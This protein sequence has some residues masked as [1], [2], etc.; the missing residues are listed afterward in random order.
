MSK[1]AV[2]E[3]QPE[4]RPA[5]APDTTPLFRQ[6][7]L[8]ERRT[9]WLG[10]VLLEPRVS[11]RIAARVAVFSALA[12]I[13]I[14]VFGN[15][16]RKERISGWLVPDKGIVRV[17]APGNGIVTDLAVKEGERVAKG[18]PLVT[19]SSEVRTETIGATGEEIV[20]KLSARRS[21]LLSQRA[22]EERLAAQQ[23]DELA[24]R[25][26]ALADEAELLSGEISLQKRRIE[27]A[28]DSLSRAEH[29]RKRGI[30]TKASLGS[31]EAEH[32]DQAAKL[33]SLERSLSQVRRDLSAARK[34]QSDLP[35]RTNIR[36]GDIDREVAAVE[37][38]IAEAEA[39][40]QV[41][42]AAPQDGIV[43]AIQTEPGGNV[44]PNVPMLSIV[45][46]GSRLQAQLFSPSR[47]IGFLGKGSDVL[48]R[49]QPFP[50][51]NFGFYKGKIAS[52]SMTAMSPA[53]LPQQ[54][55]GLSEFY[56][57]NAPV[58]RITVDLERQDVTAYGRKIPLQAGM[59]LE[60]DVLIESH[61][62]LQWLLYPIFA[63]SD[64]WA[65]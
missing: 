12:V 10:T 53:E 34:E 20:R 21:T 44:V 11:H 35:Y 48:L 41:V 3:R 60:A 55:A 26:V 59:Q 30:I 6:E 18:R 25:V 22:D 7:A 46:E 9:Q 13:A 63:K 42:V 33:Q 23:S 32:I 17:L 16:T 36:L 37:Q 47:A 65:Q 40:R 56:G 4:N 51:Q 45:P 61:S 5:T 50:Y 27:L 62:L 14:L 52:V 31:V 29:L 57:A 49:Y 38:T 24:G 54:L 64:A 15:Y 43:T 2:T 8:E 39:R 58:Y 19:V 28:R 1:I